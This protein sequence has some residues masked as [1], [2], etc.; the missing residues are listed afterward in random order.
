[1]IKRKVVGFS[2][3]FGFIVGAWEGYVALWRQ[4]QTEPMR[5]FPYSVASLPPADQRALEKGIVI[6]DETELAHLLEDYLS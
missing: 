4:G 6:E 5:V 2:L 1:M 3:L